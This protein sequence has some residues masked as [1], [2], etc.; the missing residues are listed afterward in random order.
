M[1]NTL[2]T[3]YIAILLSIIIF[4]ISL[5]NYSYASFLFVVL[6]PLIF[7]LKDI[8]GFEAFPVYRIL[9]SLLFLVAAFKFRPHWHKFPYK[10]FI[11]SY[12]VFIAGLLISA[13]FSPSPWEAFTHSVTYVFPLMTFIIIFVAVIDNDDGSRYI[14]NGITIGFVIVTI[15]G[16]FEL[17][18]QENILVNLGILGQDYNWLT[19][20]RLGEGRLIS[21]IGQPVYLAL[22]IVYTGVGVIFYNMYYNSNRI[23]RMLL[24]IIILFSGLCLIYTGTRTAFV[25]ILLIY[26]GL[27][28]TI[29]GVKNKINIMKF[30]VVFMAVTI[31]MAPR[32]VTYVIDSFN[33]QKEESDTFVGRYEVSVE[34]VNLFKDHII[35]GFGAGYILRFQKD[36]GDLGIAGMENQYAALL[37]DSGL[38]GFLPYLGFMVITFSAVKKIFSSNCYIVAQWSR[39]VFCM[40]LALSITSITYVYLSVIIAQILMIYLGILF[41]LAGNNSEQIDSC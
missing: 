15:Y 19:D 10:K 40:F 2:L 14:F 5:F 3:N 11:Y 38:I 8:E 36:Y 13:L 18:Y 26:S 12:L 21:F 28:I 4:I 20:I 30:I 22:Y 25:I 24:Y 6:L 37:V 29:K 41:G 23:A 31:I 16:I 17:L 35:T 34:M 33:V 1:D 39:F 7:N 27:L 9:I 32:I